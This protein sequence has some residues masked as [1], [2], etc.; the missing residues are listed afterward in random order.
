MEVAFNQPT[1][2]SDITVFAYT[3]IY[4]RRWYVLNI[5]TGGTGQSRIRKLFPTPHV[6]IEYMVCGIGY[7][8]DALL[9]K[10]GGPHSLRDSIVDSVSYFSIDTFLPTQSFG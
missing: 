8:H 5:H 10:S 3:G 1:V 9:E 4:R 6:F 7:Y 2:E